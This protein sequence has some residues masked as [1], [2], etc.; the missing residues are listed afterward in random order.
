[1]TN[2]WFKTY[3]VG[4]VLVSGA[5]FLLPD[6]PGVVVW[7]ALALSMPVAILIG[8]R[9]FKPDRRRPWL[10]IVG[11]LG[12][13]ALGDTIWSLPIGNALGP[14]DIAY[15]VGYPLIAIGCLLLARMG[16][17]TSVTRDDRRADRRHG[18]G[19]DP[20]GGRAQQERRDRAVVRL[21]GQ[22]VVPRVRHLDR[23]VVD[24]ARPGAS[25]ARAGS[26]VAGRRVRGHV[27][28]GPGLRLAPATHV[29]ALQPLAR[30]RVA[31]QLP[32]HRSRRPAS[33]HG[34]PDAERGAPKAGLSP[35]DVLSLG[36]PLLA[37]PVLMLLPGHDQPIDRFVLGTP[38]RSQLLE[39]EL[40]SGLF[41]RSR[42]GM[43]LTDSGRTMLE[44]ARRALA[45][46]DR[47]RAEIQPAPGQL[48]GIV[49]IGLLASTADL[50]AEALVRTVRTQH[51]GLMLRI[52]S[53]YAGHLREWLEAGDVD[54]A[55]LYGLKP[56][57]TID[58]HPQVR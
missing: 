15:V 36:I 14:S 13:F 7:D 29:R 37:V 45:E 20:V 19:G 44:R 50:L 52:D 1:M 12:A 48:H 25:G 32:L 47:A 27:G 33:Q 8:L 35:T 46:L 54:L 21:G 5:Y 39:L 49:T 22:R 30:P 58:V 57:S 41:E 38:G 17:R 26:L 40:G 4:G 6:G 3:L 55:L 31:D 56:S 11:G 18:P 10:F 16:K 2:R 34:P 51:P 28:D 24:Q 42:H 23:H 43:R 9:R 53:G